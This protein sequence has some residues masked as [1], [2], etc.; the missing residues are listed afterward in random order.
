M[1]EFWVNLAD[2]REGC[3]LVP[4]LGRRPITLY[5]K[6]RLGSMPVSVQRLPYSARPVIRGSS[7]NV[8]CYT[9]RYC[10]GHSSYPHRYS[11]AE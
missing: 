2:G 4:K 3:V 10:A 6:R 9:P 11:C 5:L 8:L 7:E 1:T